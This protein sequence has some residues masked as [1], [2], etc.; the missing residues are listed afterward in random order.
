M[1]SRP[2]SLPKAPAPGSSGAEADAHVGF[3]RNPKRFNVAITRAKALLVR[4]CAGTRS[5]ISDSARRCRALAGVLQP[6]G[7]NLGVHACSLASTIAAIC[8][9]LA[10]QVGSKPRGSHTEGLYV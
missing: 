8:E 3:W 2:E 9:R 4:C 7:A 1:L 5:L 6:C 10:G